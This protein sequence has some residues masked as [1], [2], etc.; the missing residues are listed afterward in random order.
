[1]KW[2]ITASPSGSLQ[3]LD[4]PRSRANA[5]AFGRS[6]VPTAFAIHPHR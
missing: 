6:I 4:R 2:T 1:M 5:A 3:L